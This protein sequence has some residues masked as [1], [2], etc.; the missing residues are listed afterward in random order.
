VSTDVRELLHEAVA[1]TAAPVPFDTIQRR[2]GRRRRTRLGVLGVATAL[3]I[4]ALIAVVIAQV[5]SDVQIDTASRRVSS[6]SGAPGSSVSV[7]LPGGWQSLPLEDVPVPREILAVGTEAR[8]PTREGLLSA[9]CPI[10]STG[11]SS[12]AFIVVSE[13]R[14]TDPVIGP[15]SNAVQSRPLSPR[16]ENFARAAVKND[17]VATHPMPEP[18]AATAPTASPTSTSMRYLFSDHGRE[19]LAVVALGPDAG[20]NR[21]REAFEILNSFRIAGTD[22]SAAPQ[23]NGREEIIPCDP[24]DGNLQYS[25]KLAVAEGD[26]G[27]IHWQLLVYD[28]TDGTCV[29][30]KL[31]PTL[32]AGGCG[33]DFS[34]PVTIGSSGGPA[35]GQWIHGPARKDV[36]RLR[37]VLTNGEEVDVAPVGQDA[38]MPV[39][40][41][42]YPLPSGVQ[43][44]EVDAIDVAGTQIDLQQVP[45]NPSP[46]VTTATAT[47]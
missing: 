5:G 21:E 15:D 42:V 45:S 32:S 10:S 1:T 9:L 14:P 29:D 43:A 8:P 41:F 19:F 23:C 40:F 25:E 17:C 2:A 20:A 38:D 33:F 22:A 44:T 13:Y 6:A 26:H 3:G 16:P 24:G 37:V 4:S 27:S 36:A 39:N 47:T 28:S 31:D 7:D 30:L 34:R 18:G 35:Y 46:P 11:A 12:A